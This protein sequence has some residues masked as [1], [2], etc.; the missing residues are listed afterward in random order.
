MRIFLF[1][2]MLA[3]LGPVVAGCSGS[4]TVSEYA[5]T[6]RYLLPKDHLDYQGPHSAQQGAPSIA[7][8]SA[9]KLSN[10]EKLSNRQSLEDTFAQED[11]HLRRVTRICQ[12][13]ST[14]VRAAT[15]SSSG[16]AKKLAQESSN[17]AATEN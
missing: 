12:D 2:L 4:T 7:S 6:P 1:S 9:E 17:P 16:A 11:A 10:S 13:C 5:G 14:I 15:P 8:R 3:L